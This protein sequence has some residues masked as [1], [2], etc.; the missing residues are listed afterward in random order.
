[1]KLP[2]IFSD[3]LVLQ[4]EREAAIWGWA[5]PGEKVTVSLG[6]KSAPTI[7]DADGHWELKLATGAPSAQPR[8]LAVCAKNTLTVNDVLVGEVWLA[9]GQSNMEMA[10]RDPRHGAVDRA[11]EEIAAANYPAIRVFVHD[12]RYTVYG[13]GVPPA[14]P[15]VDRPGH[16]TV[17]APQT[18][19]EF[20]AIA[21][22]FAR[23]LHR[24]LNRPIGIIT[25][26]VGGTPI[27]AWTSLPPQQREAAFAP[28]LANWEKQ[29]TGYDPARAE[30]AFLEQK[31]AWLKARTAA[32]KAGEP[33]PKAPSP[34]KNN[35]VMAPGV[36]FNAYIA[37]V[38]PYTLRGCIWYQGER[39]A[40]GPFT[41]LY[42]PQLETMIRDWRARWRDDFYF[43]W[44][45]LPGFSKPQT[46]P[47]EP[48]G[49]GVSVRDGMRR[50]LRL[51]HTG[52]AI[53]IDLG[54]EKAGH[55]TNKAD[56]ATR[57]SKVV[58][59]DVYTEPSR[60]WSGPLFRDSERAG[61]KMLLR[62]D[63][64]DGLRPGSGEKLAG[65]AIAGADRKFIWAE[66]AVKNG[67]VEVWSAQVPEPVA[68]R[69]AWA[70]NPIGNLVNEAGLPASPFR[71]DD[72][73]K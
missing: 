8:T 49:W 71:T 33:A 6:E 26:A 11:D 67:A 38:I 1:V 59:H 62:F 34:F 53:T 25:A 24:P 27:E 41:G 64:T 70:A 32:T 54:G 52:M 42:G 37:P 48:A 36:L 23:D 57:L 22:F 7:A 60:I 35:A 51:P 18:A 19:A 40:N 66:T 73:E 72:W 63:H 2:A 21:Y 9:A 4:A 10:L 5:A 65:F 28:L 68:V 16:W 13:A 15:L 39:N 47:S 44:V 46:L 50:A 61:A 20:S 55:P 29:L 69:Y 17:C 58:L 14:E 45:Q 56:F 3:H 30:T 31:K 12:E 43:A